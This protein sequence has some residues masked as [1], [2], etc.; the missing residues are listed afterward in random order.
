MIRVVVSR[1]PQCSKPTLIRSVAIPLNAIS[2]GGNTYTLFLVVDGQNTGDVFTDDFDFGQF[3]RTTLLS[4]PPIADRRSFE[5]AAVRY[6]SLE[7]AVDIAIEARAI[8]PYI[9]Y[10]TSRIIPNTHG[11]HTDTHSDQHQMQT[12]GRSGRCLIGSEASHYLA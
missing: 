8:D 12:L 10:H 1:L 3:R 5:I 11:T 2:G 9:A 4:S 7:Q 6:E